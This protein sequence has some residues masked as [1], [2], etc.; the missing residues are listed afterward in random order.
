MAE[1]SDF[2]LADGGEVDVKAWGPY[3]HFTLD[4]IPQNH[5]YIWVE[6]GGLRNEV[7]QNDLE[8]VAAP[9]PQWD[10]FSGGGVEFYAKGNVRARLGAHF[11]DMIDNEV[12]SLKFT[13]S[14]V[15][16]PW[17]LMQ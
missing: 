7:T 13:F 3:A 11:G 2:D 1:W 17:E 16:V 10:L 8:M 12:G 9:T 15:F 4:L 6:F 14:L 5:W